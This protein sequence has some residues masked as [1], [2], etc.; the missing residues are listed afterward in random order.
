MGA[1]MTT[2]WFTALAVIAVSIV[3]PIVGDALAR[4]RARKRTP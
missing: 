4:H 3:L 2:P 1:D